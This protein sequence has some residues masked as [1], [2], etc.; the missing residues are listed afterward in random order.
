MNLKNSISKHF[1]ICGSHVGR[2]LGCKSG[3]RP[4]TRKGRS[5]RVPVWAHQAAV[6][7]VPRKN[8]EGRYSLMCSRGA[9]AGFKPAPT[10]CVQ[11]CGQDACAPRLKLRMGRIVTCPT[12]RCVGAGLNPPLAVCCPPLP[13]RPLPQP[14]GNSP[15]L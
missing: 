7:P 13:F 8:P 14:W 11:I 2:F 10:Y 9:W 6:I 3:D 5:A 4:I 15:F 12:I 1:Q